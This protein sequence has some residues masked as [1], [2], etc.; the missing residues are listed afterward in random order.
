MNTH[1]IRLALV[2]L[3]GCITADSVHAR[4]F[5]GFRGGGFGGGSY[6]FDR[7]GSVSGWGG[8][9]FSYSGSRSGG[10]SDYGG[11]RGVGGS[12]DRSLSDARGG[13]VSVSGTRGAAV[14][15]W[16]GAAAGGTRTISG[17]TAGGR[18]F[19]TTTSRGGVMGPGGGFV[20]GGSRYGVASG[21]RGTVAGGGRWGAAGVRFPT[22]AGLAHY[23][24]VGGY[25]VVGNRTALWSHSYVTTRAG[26]VRSGFLWHDSFNPAWYT[27]HPGAWVA[28]GWA[29]NAAWTV[30]TWPA[31]ATF[32]NISA[33]PVYMDYGNTVVYQNN[34]VYVDGTDAGTAEE[35]NQQAIKLA[36]AGQ[37]AKAPKTDKWQSLGVF[38]LVQGDEK[39][40]NTM[41]ELAVDKNGVIRGNY[42]DALMGTSTEVFGS[43]DP[44]TQR[45]AWTIGKNLNTVF[46]TGIYNL[47]KEETPVL[48]HFGKDKTQQWLLVRMEQPKQ[49]SE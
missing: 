2:V 40:S 25:G 28:A 23:S 43:V 9:G 6:S 10:F 31:L 45:A 41:F 35:Y 26:Y 34:N 14:G 33:P 18:S 4:G 16:G 32:V 39:T 11:Y 49:A 37:E 19:D 46:E 29:A 7:G 1:S 24:A 21:P 36:T 38:S 3:I 15:P 12:Y 13:S 30:A 8:R 44:K 20:A 27:A 17:T 47:T 22:D 48:V 5:G 42:Y